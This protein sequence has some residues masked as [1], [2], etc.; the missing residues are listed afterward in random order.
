MPSIWQELDCSASL[1]A[2]Q[3]L[4][5]SRHSQTFDNLN[6]YHTHNRTHTHTHRE[7]NKKRKEPGI[8]M[9]KKQRSEQKARLS[10][11]FHSHSVKLLTI[12]LAICCQLLLQTVGQKTSLWVLKQAYYSHYEVT[13]PKKKIV[14]CFS[15]AIKTSYYYGDATAAIHAYYWLRDNLKWSM[16]G[17]QSRLKII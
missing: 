12:S 4:K 9:R 6:K 14:F 1:G 15:F 11:S 7:R 3:T 8:T 13:Q 17:D 10:I 2:E 16:E 5:T